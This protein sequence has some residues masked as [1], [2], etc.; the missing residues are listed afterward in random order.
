VTVL[1]EPPW[2]AV[3]LGLA[4]TTQ[5]FTLN[6]GTKGLLDGTYGLGSDGGYTWTDVSEYVYVDSLEFTRGA[7]RSQGPFWRY[8]AGN[9]GFVLDNIDGRFDPLNDTTSP[10]RSGGISEIRPGL[11]VRIYAVV[12]GFR[13]VVWTGVLDHVDIDYSSVIWSTARFVCVDGV[14][15]LQSADLPDRADLYGTGDT[16]SDRMERILNAAGWSSTARL[17]DDSSTVELQ[18]TYLGGPVWQQL[19]TTSDAEAGYMWLDRFG[20]F[21]YR[22]RQTIRT[23]PSVTFTSDPDVG[24]YDY[25]AVTITRDVDQVYNLLNLGR[26]NYQQQSYESTYQQAVIGQVRGFTRTDLACRYEADVDSVAWWLLALYSQLRTRVE[27]VEIR[28][29]A[30]VA[31]MT[32]EEWTDLV[33]LEVGDAVRV[34]HVTPDGRTLTM[35]SLVRGITWKVAERDYRLVL[36]LQTLTLLQLSNGVDANFTLDNELIGVL[37][38]SRLAL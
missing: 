11:P 10:Y 1:S 22:T 16:V 20:N 30:D 6:D 13:D 29:Q 27:Q 37:D 21:T 12:N 35:D 32:V 33:R 5:S 26:S 3:E 18:G 23:A 34:V 4:S 7:T 36:S 15:A 8:E 24:G 25:D 2:F 9:A 14:E 28:P 38:T 19:S 17:V 31:S